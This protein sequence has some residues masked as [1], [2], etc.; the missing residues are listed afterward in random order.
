MESLRQS[1]MKGSLIERIMFLMNFE[2]NGKLYSACHT[3][4]RQD[5]E[6]VSVYY[7]NRMIKLTEND[8]LYKR[9]L[10]AYAKYFQW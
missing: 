7:I 10:Y 2:E 8:S 3:M 1:Y 5:E 9:F 6:L 4:V